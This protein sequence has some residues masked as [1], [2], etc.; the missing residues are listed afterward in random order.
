[1]QTAL[2]RWV[3]RAL[4][5]LVLLLAPCAAAAEGSSGGAAA[6]VDTCRRHS[7]DGLAPAGGSLWGAA[8]GACPCRL[9]SKGGMSMGRLGLRSCQLLVQRYCRVANGGGA[10]EGACTCRG[11]LK[12]TGSAD[13]GQGCHSLPA[14][15][16]LL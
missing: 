7:K 16:V 14:E 5:R 1:M 10:T 4:T 8:A 9:Y 3:G 15:Y 11:D 6:G 13:A 2:K 12:K